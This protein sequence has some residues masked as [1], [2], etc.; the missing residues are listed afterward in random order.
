MRDELRPALVYD[1]VKDDAMNA[2]SFSTV[3]S[4]M[5]LAEERR[6]LGF[7]QL[8]VGQ[9]RG[10]FLEDSTC[11]RTWVDGGDMGMYMCHAGEVVALQES[12]GRQ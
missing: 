4:S 10:G 7:C 11:P 5:S 8:A 9:C 1:V 12:D 2:K 3:V 6:S